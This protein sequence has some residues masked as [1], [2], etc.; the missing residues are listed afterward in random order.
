MKQKSRLLSAWLLL[1][2]GFSAHATLPTS[3]AYISDPQSEYVQDQTSEGTSQASKILCYMANT[4]PDAMVNK[5]AY[6]AFI[7]ESKCGTDK[8]N[9]TNSS[10]ESVGSSTEYTRMRLTSTRATNS[11]PQIVKGHASVNLGQSTPGYVY[12]YASGT[13][14]PSA[15]AP[16]GVVTMEMSGLAVSNNQRLMRGKIIANASGLQFSMNRS[17]E[18]TSELQSH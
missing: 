4:R 9:A 3:G 13:D 5:P 14:A 16:N 18:H 7:D 12:I 10:S 11:S 2:S 15:S 6:V 17:E 1:V 8:A